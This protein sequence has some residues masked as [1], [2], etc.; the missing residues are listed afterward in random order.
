MPEAIT[1]LLI[2][3]QKKYK[4]THIVAGSGAFGKVSNSAI[5]IY[6]RGVLLDIL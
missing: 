3:V 2:E 6:E 4:F 1:P 5:H